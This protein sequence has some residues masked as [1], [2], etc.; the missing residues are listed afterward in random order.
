MTIQHIDPK[1]IQANP[2]QTRGRD[3]PEHLRQLTDSIRDHGLLSPPVGRSNGKGYQLAFGHSRLAAF[4]I[5]RPGDRFPLDVRALT[6]RQMAEHAITENASRQDIDPIARARALKRYLDEFKVS[7]TEAGKLFGLGSQGA[8]SNTLR[9]LRLPVNVLDIVARGDL[10]ERDARLLLPI[11]RIAGGDKQVVTIA[12]HAAKSPVDQRSDVVER[13]MRDIIWRHHRIDDWDLSWPGKPIAVK[14]FDRKKGE[15]AEVPACAGCEF[16]AQVDRHSYCLRT[17]C[18]EL[19][20]KLH[21]QH[22]V[23]RAAKKLGVPVVAQ[24]ETVETVYNG[25]R[26]DDFARQSLKLRNR[27]T[28]LRLSPINQSSGDW[29]RRNLLGT[30][31]AELV[32]IDMAALRRALPKPKAAA[33]KYQ[34]NFNRE[35]AK[36]RERVKACKQLCV[37]AGELLAAALPSNDSVLR[38]IAKSLTGAGIGMTHA[39]AQG[40]LK[41][42]S[43]TALRNLTMQ[44]ML[45]HNMPHS[46]WDMNATPATVSKQIAALANQLNVKLPRGWDDLRAKNKQPIVKTKGKKK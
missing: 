34:T 26:G 31:H 2:W 21:Q 38:L 16:R 7:Q 11:L 22:D 5:A 15:P 18:F 25:A 46:E 23:E 6:D 41:K 24:G 8:V 39:Q 35:Q 17:A 45:L 40:V 36:R 33:N 20:F 19:K 13:Q 9:L 4:Q 3:D 44:W 30:E 37:K 42:A 28:L 12:Q 27:A 14:D 29:S 10:A 43:G 32:T 1:L